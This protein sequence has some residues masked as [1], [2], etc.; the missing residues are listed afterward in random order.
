[1]YPLSQSSSTKPASRNNPTGLEHDLKETFFISDLHLEKVRP[2]IVSIFENFLRQDCNEI[3]ALYILGDLFEAWVGDDHPVD[4][5]ES[6]L[7]ALSALA[8]KTPVYFLHGNR[9]FL[10][11]ESFAAK[12]GLHLLDEHTVIELY[13][14]PALVMHGDTLCTD[15]LEYQQFRQQVRSKEFQQDFLKHPLEA[16][17]E[18]ARGI[19]DESTKRTAL[20]DEMITD[21]NPQEVLKLMQEFDV[22]LLIHGHTHRPATHQL[23]INNKAAERI[24]LSDWYDHGQ[25]LKCS[26]T[27]NHSHKLY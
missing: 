20:K 9:D 26:A 7:D 6:C 12:H 22:D 17:L 2:E 4:G 21:V 11:G 10:L 8:Q 25:V 19:R 14:R 3:D 23:E 1:M 24:V 5:L 15:D 27:G 18:Q 13:G 16:R